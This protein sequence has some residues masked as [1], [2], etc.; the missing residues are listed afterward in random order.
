MSICQVWQAGRAPVV[1]RESN[2]YNFGGGVY[3]WCIRI[4]VAEYHAR[5]F[6]CR[7]ECV[8]L[9]FHGC[10]IERPSLLLL[11]NV[12]DDCKMAHTELISNTLMKCFSTLLL[13]M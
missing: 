5:F 12:L 2:I 7:K 8:K 3:I 9:W 4:W 6:I 1:I 13:N 10:K 11:N